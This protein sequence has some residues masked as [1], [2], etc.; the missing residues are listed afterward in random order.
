MSRYANPGE[1]RYEVEKPGGTYFD[2]YVGRL[3]VLDNGYV[4]LLDTDG[5]TLIPPSRV[6]YVKLDPDNNS[7]GGA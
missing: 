6:H 4:E 5:H 1:V 2:T 3:E 7:T